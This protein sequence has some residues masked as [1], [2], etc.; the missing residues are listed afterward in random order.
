MS[1]RY[2]SLYPVDNISVFAPGAF[3]I[4]V[5]ANTGATPVSPI[6][7]PSYRLGDGVVA[8][9]GNVI[10]GTLYGG[11]NETFYNRILIEPSQL[12][13]GNLLSNQTRVIV[14]WN[15]FLTSKTLEAFQRNNDAGITVN[16]PVAPPYEIRPLEQLNYILNITTDGPSV[17]DADYVWTI[18]GEEYTAAVTGRRVITWPYAPSWD[19]PVTETLSWLTNV[20]RSYNGTEQRRGLRTKPRRSFSY[21]FKTFRNQSARL[22]NLLWGWQNRLYALP[23]WTDKSRSATEIEVGDLLITLT[24]DTYSFAVNELAVLY[25]GPDL[26]EI[27]EI[28]AVNSGSLSLKRPVEGNWPAR[29]TVMPVVLGHLPVRVPLMRLSSQAVVGTLTFTL[30]PVSNTSYIPAEV[31]PITYKGVE[32]LTRQP[33]WNDSLANSF[34]YMFDQLDQQTGAIT[35]DT[36]EEFPRINRQYT[37]LLN[38]RGKI[39]DFRAMLGRRLGMRNSIYV[40]SWHDDFKVTRPIGASDTGISVLNNEFRLMVGT[41]PARNQLMIRLVNGTVFYRQIVGVSADD[42][43]T[44]LTVDTPLGMLVPLGDV[45]TIHVMMLSRLATDEVN[46]VWRT[47][48]VAQVDT[49]FTSILE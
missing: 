11:V 25:G 44:I 2:P 17:I 1:I 41:D 6:R 35:W 14:V 9:Q 8:E 30:D 4:D 26:M 43:Y 24:T 13:M 47:D 48:H 32:V 45:K 28:A 37:W 3:N 7:Q 34:D 23:V 15:G 19:T 12:D 29:T 39:K 40:P 10:H 49:T 20:L 18:D 42:Q 16:E 27:V 5:P 46:I 22:E 31:P 36:T 38:G 21:T 33:N